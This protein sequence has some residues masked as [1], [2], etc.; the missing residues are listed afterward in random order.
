LIVRGP[1]VPEGVTKEQ[2]VL[3]NDLAPTFADLAQ[4]EAPD[5]VDGRSLA[6]LLTHSAPPRGDWRKAFLVEAAAELAGVP[7]PPFFNENR[8][9]PLLTGDPLPRQDS[10][11]EAVSRGDSGRPGL[12]ALRTEDYLYVEYETGEREL[13]DLEKDPYQLN[14]VYESSNPNLLWRLQERLGQLRGCA[15]INCR[16][17]EDAQPMDVS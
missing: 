13:Y 9:K 11:L 10:L 15:G 6:P 8:D 5:F 2:V 17:V 4:T 3:N 1:G 14:N 16:A 7:A 12:K